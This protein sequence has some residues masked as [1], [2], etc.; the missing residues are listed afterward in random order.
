MTHMERSKRTSAIK[1][2]KIQFKDLSGWLKALVIL[3]WIS[4]GINALAFMYGF[5]LGFLGL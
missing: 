2:N 4:V 5:T 1:M 3:G